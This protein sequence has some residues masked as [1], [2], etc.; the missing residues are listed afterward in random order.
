MSRR[1]RKYKN[2]LKREKRIAMEKL[3]DRLSGKTR[4]IE[5]LK[6]K[7]QR[8]PHLEEWSEKKMKESR[9]RRHKPT[10]KCNVGFEYKKEKR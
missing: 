3:K 7:I 8:T 10:I 5:R 4:R 9:E 2:K 6:N 1:T